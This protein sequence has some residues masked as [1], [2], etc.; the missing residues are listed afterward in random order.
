MTPNRPTTGP[1]PV[2]VKQ[3]LI[4]QMQYNRVRD[5]YA[6]RLREIRMDY[7]RAEE[8]RLFGRPHPVAACIAIAIVLVSF[9]CGFSLPL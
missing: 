6:D 5:I 1:K 8:Q 4:A 3:L 9:V 7:I 2:T